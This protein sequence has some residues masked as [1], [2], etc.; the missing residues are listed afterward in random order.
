MPRGGKIRHGATLGKKKSRA[1]ETWQG[2]RKRCYNKA[3]PDYRHYGGRGIAVCERWSL[4]ENF[5]IDMG[6]PPEGMTLD[7]INNDGNYSPDNCRW[8]TRRQQSRNTRSVRMLE[9]R[10]KTQCVRDWERELGFRPAS[11]TM[12]LKRGWPIDKA[13]STSKRK[14][15]R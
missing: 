2:M 1:Y 13:L 9:F 8:A 10:G 15:P 3:R 11:I 6:N 4:F 12:R 5:L 14:F 7:R